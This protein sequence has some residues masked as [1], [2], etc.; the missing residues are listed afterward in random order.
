MYLTKRNIF[1]SKTRYNLSDYEKNFLRFF[2]QK[3]EN[4]KI[5]LFLHT[6]HNHVKNNGQI[7]V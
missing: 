1:L 5:N 3:K 2:F 6:R 4:V 7:F